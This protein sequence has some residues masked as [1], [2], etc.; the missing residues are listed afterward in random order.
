[1]K[2]KEILKEYKDEADEIGGIVGSVLEEG[3][4]KLRLKYGQLL[5][6]P[7]PP[8]QTV[9]IDVGNL[10]RMP[11]ALL[12]KVSVKYSTYLSKNGYPMSATADLTVRALLTSL[13]SDILG[14]NRNSPLSA[15]PGY[16]E[17]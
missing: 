6:P 8:S 14:S 17:D 10:I 2:P 1:M 9:S 7:I 3:L 12:E 4:D 13:K 15:T 16:S 5:Y 11:S